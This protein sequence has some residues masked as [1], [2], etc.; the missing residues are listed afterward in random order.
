MRAVF[1]IWKDRIAPVF[2]VA[3]QALVIVVLENGATL[4]EETLVLPAGS[5]LAKVTSLT[6]ARADVLIC[7]A[8]S[9]PASCAARASG[10]K[11]H[12]FIAGTVREVVEAWLTGRLEES[13]FAM[14]GCG[15]K[16]TC[17]RILSR[18]GDPECV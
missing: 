5:A 3:G 1:T 15:S 14:P 6:D 17:H 10:I 7:G 16:H 2:D 12:P 13:A 8:I 18:S 9:R 11:V 4:A